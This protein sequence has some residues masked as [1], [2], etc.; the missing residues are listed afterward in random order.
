M[1]FSVCTAVSLVL[2]FGTV[3]LTNGGYLSEFFFVDIRDTGMDFF[4]SMAETVGGEPYS[5]YGTVYPPLANLFFYVLQQCVPSS[6]STQWAPTHRGIMAMRGTYRDLRTYQAPLVLFLLFLLVTVL[7]LAALL[8][9]MMKDR[10]RFPKA[11]AVSCCLCYGTLYAY[12]RGNILIP[13]MLCT[14]FFVCFYRSEHPVLREL[15][16]ISLA[17]AAGLKLYPALF[18]LLLLLDKQ[19]KPAL[20]TVCYGLAAFFLPFFAFGGLSDLRLFLE[21][22][23]SFN[24]ETSQALMGYGLSSIVTTFYEE[25][26]RKFDIALPFQHQL[27]LLLFVLVTVVLLF[28]LVKASSQWKRLLCLTLLL[29]FLQSSGGYT[30]AFFLIPF[31]AFLRER[32]T[33]EKQDLPWFVCFLILLLPYPLPH[34]YRYALVV[35]ALAVLTLLVFFFCG[36]SEFF[37]R[38]KGKTE[39]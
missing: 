28:A 27:T 16:L 30:L 26:A 11:A 8:E 38:R 7:A 6:I 31:L 36:R 25:A 1:I 17:I 24:S 2:L 3:L 29:L 37:S 23:Y 32:P 13:A 9:Y 22:F 34:L 4:N 5:R 39:A 15:A 19:W 12:E 21:I 33:L 14:L 10:T 35:A 20:R 18:G